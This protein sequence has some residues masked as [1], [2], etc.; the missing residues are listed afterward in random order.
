MTTVV[1]D[2]VDGSTDE[3]VEDVDTA[4]RLTCLYGHLSCVQLLLERGAS[5]EAK[6]EDGGIPLH[7]ACAGVSDYQRNWIIHASIMKEGYKC[8]YDFFSQSENK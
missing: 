6:D 2:N 1:S 5:V 4:L 8:Q 3:P 7:D